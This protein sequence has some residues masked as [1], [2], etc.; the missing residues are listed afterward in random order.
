MLAAAETIAARRPSVGRPRPA[1]SPPRGAPGGERTGDATMC[2][3]CPPWTSIDHL[4]LHVLCGQWSRWDKALKH[5][6]ACWRP[7]NISAA[8]VEARLREQAAAAEAGAMRG[9]LRQPLLTQH[10]RL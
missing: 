1:S 10:P 2:F 7:W 9:K 6:P 4:H 3:H 8:A 5:R